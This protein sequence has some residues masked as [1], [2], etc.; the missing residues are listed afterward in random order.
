MTQNRLIF[1]ASYKS[2]P[3]C[4]HR[5]P[6][7]R[8]AP[9]AEPR[10]RSSAPF[11]PSRSL[12]LS[13]SRHRAN[14]SYTDSKEPTAP[15]SYSELAKALSGIIPPSR[16]RHVDAM[17]FFIASVL[18]PVNAFPMFPIY[19]SFFYLRKFLASAT[20]TAYFRMSFSHFHVRKKGTQS[21][22]WL[23]SPVIDSS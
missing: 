21:T 22:I 18:S 4:Y 16:R 23:V 13:A 1:A 15:R 7:T 17:S 11:G 2:C 8:P 6:H 3:A 12:T 20:L 5:C 9:P 19:I 14:A 10:A